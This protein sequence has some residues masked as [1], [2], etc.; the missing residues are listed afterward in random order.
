MIKAFW[1]GSNIERLN[2]NRAMSPTA[3]VAED[4]LDG[5]Q[6]KKKPLVLP[7]IDSQLKGI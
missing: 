3:Y 2:V 5:H 1:H 6:W 4:G 7:W